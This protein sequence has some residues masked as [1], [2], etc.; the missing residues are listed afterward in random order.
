MASGAAFFRIILAASIASPRYFKARCRD[1]SSA[2]TYL[3]AMDLTVYVVD[4]D[5]EERKRIDA[6]L[7]PSVEAVRSLDDADAL[8][9]VLGRRDGVCLIV[10]VEPDGV[11]ALE[12]AREL[13]LLGSKVPLV[14]VGNGTALRTATD[15]AR[16]EFTDFVERPLSAHKLRAAVKRACDTVAPQ[17]FR[18]KS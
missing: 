11:A 16:L 4:S 14:A 6:M 12:L 17:S 3:R 10:S 7:S 15:I 13:R 5:P 1:A 2:P 8:L 9:A 18:L